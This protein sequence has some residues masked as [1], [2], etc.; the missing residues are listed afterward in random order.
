MTLMKILENSIIQIDLSDEKFEIKKEFYDD[1][2]RYTE[3]QFS[4]SSN[5]RQG[6]YR[7]YSIFAGD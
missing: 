6:I 5:E 3:G 7:D 4:K 2:S 1:S